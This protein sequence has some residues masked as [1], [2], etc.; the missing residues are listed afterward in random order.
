MRVPGAGKH[1]RL[2]WAQS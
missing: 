2:H 1:D